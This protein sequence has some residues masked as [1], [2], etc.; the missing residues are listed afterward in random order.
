MAEP[1]ASAAALPPEDPPGVRVRSQGLCVGPKA[2]FSVEEPM[3]NSSQLSRPCR[4]APARLEVLRH[5][6][7]VR[8]NEIREHLAR[9]GERLARDCDHVLESD[10]NAIERTARLAGGTASVG[11]G[12]L[13]KRVGLVEGVECTNTCVRR[14]LCERAR[15]A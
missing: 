2:E 13:R 9:C 3:A 6:G 8:R 12:S 10:R 7:I 5:R 14:L 1:A 11:F 4:T 15:L